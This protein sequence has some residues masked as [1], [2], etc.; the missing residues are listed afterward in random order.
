[1]AL[2]TGQSA[3]ET[4]FKTTPIGFENLFPAAT[5]KVLLCLDVELK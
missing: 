1:V 3:F 5:A 2:Q 4:Y